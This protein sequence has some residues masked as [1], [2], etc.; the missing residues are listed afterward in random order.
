MGQEI[1]TRHF[2]QADFDRF[3]QQLQKETELLAQWFREGRLAE[4]GGIGGFELEAWLV[5]HEFLPTPVNEEYLKALDSEW[6]TPELSRFNVELN[7]KPRQLQGKAL[8]KM[9]LRLQENWDY[10]RRVAQEQFQA[11]LVMVG[12]L[13]SLREDELTLANMSQMVRYRALNEQVFLQRK[14]KPLKLE[15]SGREHLCTLHHDVMLEAATTSFQIHLQVDAR[16]AVRYYNASIILS[17]ATVAVSANSPYLFGYDL[18]DET[19]I[20]LFEQAVEVGGYDGASQG[21]LRRVSFGSGYARESLLECYVENLEHFPILLPMKFE[22]EPARLNHL[23]LHN[24]T[25]WR[26]NRP[27]I[28]F[29]DAGHPHLRIEHRVVPSGPTMVDMIANSAF[30]YGLVEY[31]A[32]STT[33]PE[34]AMD[35]PTARDNFYAA[36]Q[37]GLAATVRW[38]DGRKR[39]MRSLLLEELIPAATEGLRMLGVDAEEISHYMGVI[40]ARV[41]SGQNGSAWQ[42]GYVARHGADMQALTAAYFKQQNRGRPVHEWPLT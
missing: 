23:R 16:R 42:R 40:E 5:D 36:A 14:G 34:R 6:V 25:I 19:R 3:R 29:D 37:K 4:Q 26:W 33:V 22:G 12:I 15:I 8:S 28:G 11:D 2:C 24:G 30:Y 38:L 17:A 21:P 13:P 18:R 32:S 27:L 7:G 10:C 39:V 35:F 9:Q 20:S 31:L 41:E 1:D